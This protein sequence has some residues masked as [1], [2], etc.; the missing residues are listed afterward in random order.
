MSSISWHFKTSVAN[1]GRKERLMKQLGNKK[2]GV[3]NR[4]FVFLKTKSVVAQK[5]V[6]NSFSCRW[7]T[8]YGEPDGYRMDY[9]WYDWKKEHFISVA[10]TITFKKLRRRPQENS[11]ADEYS[12][13]AFIKSTSVRAAGLPKSSS[14][15][16]TIIRMKWVYFYLAAGIKNKK[17]KTPSP[18]PTSSYE[19]T[20]LPGYQRK[21]KRKM[22]ASG[23]AE[24]LLLPFLKWRVGANLCD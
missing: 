10:E 22:K 17:Q 20:L 3:S 12:Y 9:I 16:E 18:L 7:N 2:F 4:R 6:E 24:L 19:V 1:R 14:D 13:V 8:A 5:T 21:R 23:L 15:T 11:D